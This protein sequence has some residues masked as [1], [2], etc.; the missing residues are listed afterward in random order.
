MAVEH[1]HKIIDIV[2]VADESIAQAVRNAVT[3]T[4]QTIR[5]LEWFEVAEIRGRIED[6]KPVFQVQVRIGFRVEDQS[7]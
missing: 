4:S 6:N 7:L 2:G 5:N 1:T 3:R